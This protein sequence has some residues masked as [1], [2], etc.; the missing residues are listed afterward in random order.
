MLYNNLFAAADKPD[1][2]SVINHS[3]ILQQGSS[4]MD[5]GNGHL[6]FTLMLSRKKI[7]L[8]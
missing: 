1:P 8:G 3:L 4:N 5:Q 2:R 6:E 7:Y